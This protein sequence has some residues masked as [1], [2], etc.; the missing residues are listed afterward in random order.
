MYANQFIFFAILSVSHSILV[1]A[2]AVLFAVLEPTIVAL[3]PFI[4]TANYVSDIQIG[5]SVSFN[6]P[7]PTRCD[8]DN[9][10][11]DAMARGRK[12]AGH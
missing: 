9:N 12:S 8:I 6:K 11:D 7:N 5:L 2:A 1:V 4:V 3:S 10:D